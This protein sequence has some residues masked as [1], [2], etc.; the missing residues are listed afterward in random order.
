MKNSIIDIKKKNLKISGLNDYS[1]LKKDTAV[2]SCLTCLLVGLQ[3]RLFSF[4][5]K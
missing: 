1:L 3:W 2:S 5:P 4:R